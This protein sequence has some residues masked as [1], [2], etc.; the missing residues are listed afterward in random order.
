MKDYKLSDFKQGTKFKGL[1]K[2]GEEVR[3]IVE[4]ETNHKIFLCTNSSTLNGLNGERLGYKYSWY[5]NKYNFQRDFTNYF[6]SFQ[7]IG[8]EQEFEE[9]TR[10]GYLYNITRRDRG[11]GMM[12]GEMFISNVW[13]SETWYKDGK[14]Y[15]KGEHRY[16]L[17]PINLRKKELQAKEAELLKQLEE[18]R[19]ELGNE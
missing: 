11:D 6:Q 4:V 18:I 15:S 7:F 3:G 2:S 5:L 12:N 1:L 8:E 10:G 19:K 16:D 13:R 14:Y 17:I 9:L